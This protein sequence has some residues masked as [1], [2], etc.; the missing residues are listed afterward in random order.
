MLIA[1]IYARKST[2]QGAVADEQRSVARQISHARQYAAR[3][4]WTVDDRFVFVD[5]GV[6]GAEFRNR[7]GFVRLMNGL[8][9]RPLFDV[10]IM[11]E[12]SRLGREALETGYA[13]K[14][15]IG[16]GVRVFYYLEDKERTLDSPTDK[17]LMSLTAY[18]SEM[19][20]EQAQQRMVDTMTR[21]AKAGHVTG[22]QCYGYDNVP[23]MSNGVRSHVEQRINETE[24]AVIR[25]IFELAAAGVSQ[26]SIAKTLNAEGHPAP[27]SQ[28]GRPRS[29]SPS[30]VYEALHRPRYRGELV[31]NQTRK[32]DRWGQRKV[33]QR[34]EAERIVVAAPHLRIISEATWQAAHARIEFARQHT[35]VWRG[36]YRTTYLHPGHARC[37]WCGR[38]PN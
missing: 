27:R 10:L 34:P 36:P 21:K 19:E 12:D 2:D 31:W 22:G 26:L 9:P 37:A 3:K 20:R 15:I 6:S 29:W 16:A 8:K 5:D 28:Q 11:S 18:A 32:R 17:I 13:L 33:T 7:P 23:V 38:S 14:Q 1:A 35:N 25:R 4:G 30:S 24:A